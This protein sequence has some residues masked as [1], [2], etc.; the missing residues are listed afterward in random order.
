MSLHI[1][2]GKCDAEVGVNVGRTTLPARSALLQPEH[3]AGELEAQLAECTQGHRG[4]GR[5]HTPPEKTFWKIKNMGQSFL[6][7]EF[8]I[9]KNS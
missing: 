2:I 4:H 1:Q 9:D 3:G 8:K 5:E 7:K 6:I